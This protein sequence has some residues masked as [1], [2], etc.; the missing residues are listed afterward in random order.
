MF[1]DAITTF[2]ENIM[3]WLLKA[4]TLN[5]YSSIAECRVNTQIPNTFLYINNEQ[6]E[7]EIKSMIPF[8]L[9]F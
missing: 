7:T 3:N 4:E 9:A 1:T 2:V 6:V 5:G 8:I